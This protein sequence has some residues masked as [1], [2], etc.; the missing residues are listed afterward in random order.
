VDIGQEIR[1]LEPAKEGE[2]KDR[3]LVKQI[4]EHAQGVIGWQVPREGTMATKC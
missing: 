1:L 3:A 4:A 2:K